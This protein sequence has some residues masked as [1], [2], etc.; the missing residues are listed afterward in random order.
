MKF[1]FKTL[2]LFMIALSMLSLSSCLKKGDDDPS[3]SLK[4]RTSRLTGIWKLKSTTKK[5]TNTKKGSTPSTVTQTFSYDGVA[6]KT[7]TVSKIGNGNPSTVNQSD[8]YTQTITINKD[9]S[10]KDEVVRNGLSTT[11]EGN[12]AWLGSDEPAGLK[13]K[14]AFITYIT[15]TITPAVTTYTG[16]AGG[17]TYVLKK[18]SSSEIE[19]DL[20]NSTTEADGSSTVTEGLDTYSQQ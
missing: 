20:S 18:L 4:S 6:Y 10:F 13:K 7:T 1:Q 19:V 2:L 14:E 9:N 12:W 8:T 17:T 15:K 16:T 3:I 5:T 11:N